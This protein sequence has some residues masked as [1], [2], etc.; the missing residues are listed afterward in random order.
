[1][2]ASGRSGLRYFV[3][4]VV[5]AALIIGALFAFRALSKPDW[6]KEGE[7]LGHWRGTVAFGPG[8]ERAVALRLDESFGSR[9]DT[10]G[11]DLAGEVKA[12]GTGGRTDYTLNGKVRK[13]DGTS[14]SVG[15]GSEDREPGRHLN[16]AEGTW[17]GND[18]LTLDMRFLTSD[19]DGVAEGT[20]STSA[21]SGSPSEPG[22]VVTFRLKRVTEDQFSAAC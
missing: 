18:V 17:D 3:G 2:A 8:D 13:D 22:E 9:G 19:A 14:F 6:A 21:Q 11:L 20:A 4:F 7:L 1:M 5:V 16:T 10:S 15:F 12:C